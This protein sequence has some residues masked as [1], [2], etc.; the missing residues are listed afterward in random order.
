MPTPTDG[1]VI[2]AASRLTVQPAADGLAIDLAN[3]RISL[4]NLLSSAQAGNIRL[5][6]TPTKPAVETRAAEATVTA[7]KTALKPVELTFE[8]RKFTITV[9]EQ[10][11]LLVF[12]PE[13]G[14]INWQ[15]SNE[16]LRGLLDRK[17]ASIIN[18]KMVE[19]VVMADTN[20]VTTEGRDGRQVATDRLT[21]EVKQ[22]TTATNQQPIVVPIQTIAI[23][24]KRIYPDFEP[25]RFA[26]LY[27]DISLAKQTIY[28]VNGN[29]RVAS[30][31]ISTGR[32]QNPTPT[33]TY[34]LKNKIP[35][36][37][38]RL[39]PGLWMKR[40]N[41]LART[42]DGGGYQ[43]YGIHDL[44]CFDPNCNQVEGQSHLGRPVSHGCVRVEATGAGYIYD[45]LPVG[46]PVYIH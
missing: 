16:K 37:Q 23:K 26:G 41:A 6:T 21:V 7:L 4:E 17:V 35:L 22:A 29:E 27:L 24:E 18:V 34:Y 19:R 9:E 3:F 43:G 8:E 12:A 45:N 13:N 28:V 11:N 10:Y 36:A 32:R 33:G 2:V 31:I 40:W 20:Q 15:I 25:G 1:L 38:S 5:R 30:Y 44:P 46:T 42:P 39:Y 14:Q